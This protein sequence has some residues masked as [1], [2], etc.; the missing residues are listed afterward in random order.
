M[1]EG[2]DDEFAVEGHHQQ[3]QRFGSKEHPS[4]LVVEMQP[5]DDDEDE[6]LDH[7]SKEEQEFPEYEDESEDDNIVMDVPADLGFGATHA[8]MKSGGAESAGS[9]RYN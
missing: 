8:S 7:N 3:T 9:N 6:M 4:D 2:E 5:E 1:L